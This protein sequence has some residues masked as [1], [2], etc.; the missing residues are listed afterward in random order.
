MNLAIAELF[1]KLGLEQYTEAFQKEE[2]DLSTFMSLTD[3]DLKELGVTTF[4][5]RKKM[6]NA[7]KGNGSFRNSILLCFVNLLNNEF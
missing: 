2:V 3:D 5:A 7:M 4:G 6:S 1:S